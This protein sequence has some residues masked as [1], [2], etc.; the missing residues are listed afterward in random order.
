MGAEGRIYIQDWVATVHLDAMHAAFMRFR[1]FLEGTVFAADALPQQL[2]VE[3]F[4]RSGTLAGS[5][6]RRPAHLENYG[7]WL[8][9]SVALDRR[10][11]GEVAFGRC[12][13]GELAEFLGAGG[14][15]V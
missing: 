13:L 6:T 1:D 11:L 10:A 14:R 4:S 5:R 12:S 9:P 3:E 8:K 7:H 2:A 15:S